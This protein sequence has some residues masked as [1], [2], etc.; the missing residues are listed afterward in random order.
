MAAAMILAMA[1]PAWSQ[2]PLTPARPDPNDP[3]AVVVEELVVT[4]RLP[5]PAWWT[6][7][8][9]ASTVYVLGAP[10]LAPKR[11]AWDRAVFDR[12]LA[13]ANEVILPFQDVHVTITGIFGAMFNFMRLKG[14]G[15]FEDTLDPATRAR[16]AAARE[17]LGQPAKRYDTRNALAAGLLLATDYRDRNSLT[18]TDPTKLVKLLAR[19]AHVPVSQKAYSIGPLMGA[20]IRTPPA[21]ARACFDAVLAQAEAGPR[22]TQAA[23]RAWAVG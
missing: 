19:R 6:V 23:A 8:N 7:S 21:A 5:G 13:G 20:V 9:G 12:R 16:F 22:V 17:K 11:M 15:P 14:G 18:T 1:L 2:V 3:D 4:A 10:S